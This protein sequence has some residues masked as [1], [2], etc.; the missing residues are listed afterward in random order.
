MASEL[1]MSSSDLPTSPLAMEYVNDFDLMKFEVKKEP[2]ETDRIISQCGRLIAGGSLSSTP[3]S[4]PCSSVPPS[5][6]FS[7]PSPGSGSDQKTHL[8]DYYWMTGYPQ[9]LNPEALGFSPEDAVEALIN[10]SHHPLPGAFDGY[11][12]GQQ[13][14]AAAG[15]SVPA[16]EM[17][18]AAAVV[19]AVIAAAAA[20]GGAPHYHHHHH[21][22]HHGGGGGGG[23]GGGHPHAAAPGSAPPSSASSAAG[24]GTGSGGGGGGGAGGLHHPHHG[25]GGGGGGGLHFDDRFSDEQLVTM[26]VRE[27]NRQLRGVSK[28]E[29]IRLKQKRRTLK[30]RGY[31][32]SCRFKRVQQ[33]HVLESEKNQLLQQVE[34]LKQ[35]ISRLVRERDAY[36]EKYEKLVSNGFRENGSSSDNPSSPEFFMYPRESSTTV[37]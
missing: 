14:A 15:G 24:S 30:N 3:M 8:E 9:Q 33:R 5:P 19:S 35:E 16:E 4:T 34:H 7:A 10:S 18:S 11:A 36:K 25:G 37:M 6:S 28:E 27:L 29:V 2:V 13:L 26:S 21:H 31:A 32:Q 12:R 20:Q 17:G 1:A 23:G 22:P